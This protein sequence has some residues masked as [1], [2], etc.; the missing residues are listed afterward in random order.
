LIATEKK[1]AIPPPAIKDI[2]VCTR[3][4]MDNIGNNVISFDGSGQCNYCSDF[5]RV[6]QLHAMDD[7]AG[8]QRKLDA[9]VELIRSEGQGKPYD[10]VIGLSGG[11]DSSYLAYWAWKAGL[12]PI[13]VHFDN[14]WNSELA[15]HNIENIIKTTG[16]DL[17]TYVINWDEF[18]DLQRAY[19]KAGVIDIE[20]PTDH[21]IFATL[22][23]VAREN[24]IKYL[25]S[26]T[27]HQTEG[28]LPKEWVYS[29]TDLINLQDI[30]KRFGEIPLKTYPRLGYLQ[31]FLYENVKK[32]RF[33]EPLELQPYSKQLAKE[34][35]KSAFG[36]RDYGGKHYESQFTK[37]YQ[38]YVLPTKFNVDKRKAHLST[39]VCNG[40]LSR[41]EA[42]EELKAPPIGESEVEELYNYSI[43]KL[44]FSDAE[45]R[46]IMNA[47]PVPHSHYHTEANPPLKDKLK[48]ALI[49]RISKY[50]IRK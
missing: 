48:L 28:I 18:R 15:V 20:V 37:F 24:G 27:N 13:A 6:Q 34:T 30:H 16:F 47:P 9:I 5:F 50:L 35:I 31:R 2:Q 10:C 3:C 12:K 8:N 14:G 4:V 40:E 1:A 33:V 19:F 25:L 11:V 23:K 29:K 17:Y 46:D 32:I 45:F 22:F 41:D 39:L 36:W 38:G 42:L 44:G 26:G 43:K 21:M 7:H 49:W